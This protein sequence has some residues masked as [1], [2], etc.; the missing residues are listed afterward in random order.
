MRSFDF[1]AFLRES[2]EKGGMTNN[3]Y[4]KK[5]ILIKRELLVNTRAR[6]AVQKKTRSKNKQ[7]D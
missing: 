1:F 5:E 6:R 4:N 3:Y 7:L 2:D